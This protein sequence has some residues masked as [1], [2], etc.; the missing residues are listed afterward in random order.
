MKLKAVLDYSEYLIL[1]G[2]FLIFIFQ[3]WHINYDR[4]N[5]FTDEPW[6]DL[7]Q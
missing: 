5:V 6:Q 2:Q 7:A 1:K 4:M 3:Y